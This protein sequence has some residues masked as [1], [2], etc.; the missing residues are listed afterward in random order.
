MLTE[1]ARRWIDGEDLLLFS[2]KREDI[3]GTKELATVLY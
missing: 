3:S 2:K 1:R